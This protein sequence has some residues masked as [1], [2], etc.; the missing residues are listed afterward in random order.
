MQCPRC[1]HEL[2]ENTVFCPYC[3]ATINANIVRTNEPAQ[4]ATSPQEQHTANPE[5]MP[6]NST[7][8]YFDHQLYELC[9]S[10]KNWMIAALVLNIIG[11]FIPFIG[12]VSVVITLMSIQ[13]AKNALTGLNISIVGVTRFQKAYIVNLLLLVV[14]FIIILQDLS[15]TANIILI[16]FFLGYSMVVTIWGFILWIMTYNKLEY[17]G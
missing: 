4:D 13:K 5:V 8:N 9:K 10:A 17:L 14:F 3:G 15:E 11:S 16:A 12:I 6:T 2:D 7:A 1:K